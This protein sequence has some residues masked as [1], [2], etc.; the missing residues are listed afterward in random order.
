MASPL[1]IKVLSINNNFFF[2]LVIVVEVIFSTWNF[3]SLYNRFIHVFHGIFRGIACGSRGI[4][5]HSQRGSPAS[6]NI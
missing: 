6:F 2:K 4:G 1:P 3:D 5:A